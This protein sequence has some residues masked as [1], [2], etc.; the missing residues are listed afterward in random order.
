MN[1]TTDKD[2]KTALLS[3]QDVSCVRGD[4]L[5][6]ENLNL[7]IRSGQCFHLTGP[8]GAGKTSLLRII[9][10]LLPPDSGLIT[11]QGASIGSNQGF[12]KQ[13][14]YLAHKDALKSELTAI[15]NL[16]FI[17]LLEGQVDEDSLDD[18]LARMQILNCADLPVQALSFGQRRRLAF[19]KLLLVKRNL[20]ILDEPLTGI[21]KS[22]RTLI[23]SLCIDHLE[24]NGSILLTHHQTLGST[25]LTAYLQEYKICG[26]A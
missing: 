5:L 10:G 24:R 7:T 25:P 21:D 3:I 15:E 22:G 12:A 4:R 16:R 9:C 1:Q 26:A 18:A 14:F 13:S 17:Q 23:E 19:A 8:N 2:D 6:F 20:W 11:W